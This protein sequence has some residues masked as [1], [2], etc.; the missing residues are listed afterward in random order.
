MSVNGKKGGKR[1]SGSRRSRYKSRRPDWSRRLTAAAWTLLVAVLAFLSGRYVLAEKTQ[2]PLNENGYEGL[3]KVVGP[4]DRQGTMVHYK[5]MTVDFNPELHIPNW[6]S[7]ELTASETDGTVKRARNFKQDA[8]VPGCALPQDYA[9]SG[10]DRGHMAPAGDMKW[11]YDAMQETFFLTNIC[12]QAKSLNT[13]AWKKLEEKCRQR[14]QADSAIII[15]CG[16]VLT[17]DAP[18]KEYIGKTRVAVPKRF[19]KVVLSPYREEPCG[20][21]FVMPNEYVKGGMQQCAVP[22]DSVEALTG[23]DFFS[24]LPDEV[25]E[26]VESECKFD[27]WSR[28]K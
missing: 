17:G 11:D 27:Q 6:V 22:I 24:S 3:E 4:S 2:H 19:F 10:Y 21:G 14:A 23:L 25:E 12:P 26:K 5:G 13:G 16:P 15:V 1:R 28:M 9:R 18:I 8:D 7:W 20:I